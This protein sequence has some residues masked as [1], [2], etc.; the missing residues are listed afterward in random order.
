MLFALGE[1]SG[2]DQA[3]E[4]VRN[5]FPIEIYQPED[6]GRWEEAY[7][8]LLKIQADGRA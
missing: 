6:T 2:I 7:G 5:S 4:V 1:V 3:R 8:K